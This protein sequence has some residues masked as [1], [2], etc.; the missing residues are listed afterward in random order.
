MR[1]SHAA[2]ADRRE[3]CGRYVHS[4]RSARR[5]R[6][7]HTG[8]AG[9]RSWPFLS[10]GMTRRTAGCVSTSGAAAGVLTRSTGPCRTGSA[11]SSGVVS[12]TSPRKA[13]WMTRL[14]NL[15][16]RQ[17]CFLRDLDG[18]HLLHALLTFLLFL[19]QLALAGD[20][21]PVTLGGHVFAQRAHGLPG[22]HFGPDGGLDDDLEQLAWDQLPQFLGDLLAPLVGFVAVDDDRERVHGFAVEQHVE[23]DE[24]GRAV[25]E[26]LVVERRVA[27]G[28][29]LQL[30]VEVEDD[31]GQRELPG[32]VH[33]RRVPVVHPSVDAPALLAQLH[34]RPDVFRRRH[35]SRFDVRLLDVIDRLTVWHPARVLDQL[36]RAVRLGDGVLDVRHGADQGEVEVPLEPRPHGLHV[37]Q[38]EEP[39]AKPEAER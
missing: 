16:D 18:P 32:E 12:T 17:E 36:H 3:R 14:V 34:D 39:A 6:A 1:A 15:Q 29:G 5:V 35:D 30:V 37:Q 23:L 2:S 10:Y 7:S 31:L 21:A 9:P 4:Y 8:P 38:A 24:I 22:D 28:D 11:W 25:L 27:A 13:V 20:V 33:P 26:E 19:E